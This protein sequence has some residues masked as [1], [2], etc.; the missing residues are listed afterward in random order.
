MNPRLLKKAFGY[1]SPSP[2]RALRRCLLGHSFHLKGTL[3][4]TMKPLLESG[5]IPTFFPISPNLFY[6]T[7][8]MTVR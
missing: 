3:G 2:N 1:S 7:I 4:A 8:G 5:D 6:L